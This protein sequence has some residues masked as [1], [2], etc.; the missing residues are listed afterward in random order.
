MPEKIDSPDPACQMANG[1]FYSRCMAVSTRHTPYAAAWE[2]QP[3]TPIIINSY[4]E[5]TERNHPAPATRITPPETNGPQVRYVPSVA[6]A[7]AESGIRM[8]RQKSFSASTK[9]EV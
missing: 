7:F 5:K 1:G 3:L 9:S 2:A 8:P 4:R 6:S